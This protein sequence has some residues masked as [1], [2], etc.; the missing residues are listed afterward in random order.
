MNTSLPDRIIFASVPLM[1]L[2][3][4]W[5]PPPKFGLFIFIRAPAI[6][7]FMQDRKALQFDCGII[8]SLK[9]VPQ[10]INCGCFFGFLT[11]CVNISLLLCVLVL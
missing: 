2:I 10:C 6:F 3:V 9:K 11:A 8:S 7:R 4:P 1:G 5:S